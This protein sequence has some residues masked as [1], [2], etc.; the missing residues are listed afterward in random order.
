MKW[1]PI[2]SYEMDLWGGEVVRLRDGA[3]NEE[4]GSWGFEEESWDGEE[5][6]VW[7]AWH[8][9]DG[10]YLGFEPVEWQRIEK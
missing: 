3:G 2:D 5:E 8:K 1:S 7:G 9:E 6:Y 10:S 4:I